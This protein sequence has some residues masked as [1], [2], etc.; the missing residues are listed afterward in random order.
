MFLGCAKSA[1][2][3]GAK[4][5]SQSIGRPELKGP[6]L[7]CRFMLPS[8]PFPIRNHTQHKA[9]QI[10]ILNLSST[11]DEAS[12]PFCWRQTKSSL[13]NF[14]PPTKPVQNFKAQQTKHEIINPNT[15]LPRISMNLQP[16]PSH[17]PFI[18][19]TLSSFS[20]GFLTALKVPATNSVKAAWN[21]ASATGWEA[22][23]SAPERSSSNRVATLTWE[24]IDPD[25]SVGFKRSLGCLL[26]VVLLGK[27]VWEVVGCFFWL[28]CLKSKRWEMGAT[29][30][31]LI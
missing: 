7:P 14:T 3:T 12:M 31:K 5:E 6:C 16:F 20:F 9:Y 18:Q 27:F 1:T 23:S 30:T 25:G 29:N 2:P 17:L 13:K 28:I 4:A 11:Q 15:S 8:C 21:S 19:G 22:N 10:I 26:F 24:E